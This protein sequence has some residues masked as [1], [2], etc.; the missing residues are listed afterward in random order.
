MSEFE[1]IMFFRCD[2][3]KEVVSPWDIKEHKGCGK[4]GTRRL[5]PSNLSLREMI[6]QIF[7]HPK[8]WAWKDCPQS[9]VAKVN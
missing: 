6:I 7:K 1:G 8:V 4:C 2:L 3:C 5:R 9:K